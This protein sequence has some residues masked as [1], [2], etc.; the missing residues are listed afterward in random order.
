M[1][2]GRHANALLFQHLEDVPDCLSIVQL[3]LPDWLCGRCD[4]NIAE[5][6]LRA[7]LEI[8]GVHFFE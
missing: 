5:S 3:E 2:E 8:R 1:R 7:C 6:R 4:F